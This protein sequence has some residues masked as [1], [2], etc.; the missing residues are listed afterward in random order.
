MNNRF[1]GF[2]EKRMLIFGEIV[3]R[4]WNGNLKSTEDLNTLSSDIKEKFNF[5]DEE[6]AGWGEAT[7]D[8]LCDMIN[9]HI[10]EKRQSD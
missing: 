9:H 1:N 7:V 5:T 6:L 3:K 8:K 4:Y 10:F 2:Q